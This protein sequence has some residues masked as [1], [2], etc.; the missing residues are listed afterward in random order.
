MKKSS[1]L[2]FRISAK[3]DN[4]LETAVMQ[5]NGELRDRSDF[6]YKAVI[7]YLNYLAHT[8]T[9]ED[10]LMAALLIIADAKQ[11]KTDEIR[12]VEDKYKNRLLMISAIDVKTEHPKFSELMTLIDNLPSY[13]QEGYIICLDEVDFDGIEDLYEEVRDKYFL[14]GKTHLRTIEREVPVVVKGITKK[15]QPR[16]KR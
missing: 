3:L 8:K 15:S 13:I 2:S 10:I 4:K 1:R 9:Q 12:E 7:Y 6:G 16:S 5:S 14:E 11:I